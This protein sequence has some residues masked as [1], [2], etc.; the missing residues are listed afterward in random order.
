LKFSVIDASIEEINE[1]LFVFFDSS[2]YFKDYKYTKA[3]AALVDIYMSR[4]PYGYNH[5]AKV[6]LSPIGS[7]NIEETILFADVSD[8]WSS[9]AHIVSNKLDVK[10]VDICA[11]ALSCEYPRNAFTLYQGS[12]ITRHVSASKERKWMFWQ[13]GEPL[14][15]EDIKLYKKRNIKDRLPPNEVLRLLNE[16]C[17]NIANFQDTRLYTEKAK[18][19]LWSRDI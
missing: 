19:F 14:P 17:G 11:Y 18:I 15:F 9:L 1:T 13:T 7:H 10:A 6:L 4:P 8:G 3:N 12:N 5:N 2:E 16:W